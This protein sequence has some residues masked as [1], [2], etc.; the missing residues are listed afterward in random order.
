MDD[1][2]W[3]DATDL[4]ALVRAGE[5]TPLE[6]VDA[7]IAR[8]ERC[9]PTLNAVVTPMFEQ[10]RDAARTQSRNGA[11]AGVPYLLKDLAVEYAGV[12]F[13]EGSR[14]LRDNVSAHDQE[15]T[16]RLRAAGLI[17]LGKTNTCEFGLAPTCEPL[18]FGPT[19]NPWDPSLTPSGSSGGAAAAV[20]AGMVP[21]AHANDLG[22]SIRYPASAC[23]LFG[24]KPTRARNPL[25]PEYG[26]VV[27]GMAVEHAVT[28]SVRDSAA[29]LDA[30]SGP[31]LGDP[32]D[33]PPPARPFAA[34]VGAPPG[35]LRI[36][37]TRRTPEDLPVHADCV[38]AIDD[39]MLLCEAL[40]HEVVEADLTALDAT[41]GAAI[42]TMFGAA[43]S[44][45][46]EYW[47]RK[48]GRVPEPDEIEP[49][50]RALWENSRNVTAGAFLLA[51]DDVRAFSR[52]V[53]QFLTDYD[54][55]A[56][57]T[58]GEPPMPLGEMV[59]TA[60]DPWASMRR[61]RTFVGFAGVVANITGNPA[62]S[63]PLSWN[64]AGVPVGVHFTAR[65]GDEA[66]LLRLASQLEAARPWR[67]RHPAVRAVTD[68]TR[69]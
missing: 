31:A 49:L 36:A 21:M 37:F 40:G 25:G 7:A 23:G 3:M 12:R 44:W 9:N 67:D 13:T 45:I 61:S 14:F 43:T 46:L 38:A 5:V 55:W 20:A 16:V 24:L 48:V 52:K 59:S 42:G 66:T 8:I 65:F 53:A 10:A 18:L 22:G 6:L 4:A 15:L 35:R 47:I 27:C 51:I 50:T 56:H 26:D 63:V 58:L 34:E 19:R 64:A 60:D 57:P 69:A 1:F 2:G 62:M 11:F 17:V 33:A 41:V 68:A 32:Y 39:A 30:T 54:V 29:L 28:R